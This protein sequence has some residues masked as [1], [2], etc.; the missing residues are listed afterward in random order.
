[1]TT[2]SVVNNV[3]AVLV[4]RASFRAEAGPGTMTWRAANGHV[5]KTFNRP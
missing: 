4:P 3:V 1:M 5:V 2:I